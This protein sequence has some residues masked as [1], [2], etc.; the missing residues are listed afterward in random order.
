MDP[1]S[2]PVLVRAF[3]RFGQNE[4]SLFSFL[5]SYEPFGLRAYCERDSDAVQPFRLHNL[6]D[7]VRANFGHRLAVVSYRSHWSTIEAAIE[8]FA[9]DDPTEIQVLKTV[10]LL[11][12]IN[13]DDL[14]AT[15]GAVAWAV[16]GADAAG[17]ERVAGILKRLK[18]RN[19]LFIR[20][21][22][23]G[24]PLWS[25]SSVD[26]EARIE[27]A[28]RRVPIIAQASAV[29]RELLDTRPLV[30]RRHYI[31]TGNL[32]YFAV[33][34]CTTGELKELAAK[35]GM[36]AD[37][38]ILVP[39]CETEAE[40]E[41]ALV[42]AG[43]LRNRPDGRI[44][45]VAV[46]HA[47]ERLKG[48]LL[49]RQRWEWIS[50]NTPELNSDAMARGEVSRYLQDADQRLQDRVQDFIGLN[51]L[52]GRTAL[53][54][55]LRGRRLR[56]RTGREVMALLSQLCEEC[57]EKAPRISNELVNR[58]T[59]SNSAMAARMRLIDLMLTRHREA[60]L[61][62]PEDRRPPEISMY[63]SVLQAAGLHIKQKDGWKFVT[64]PSS[65]VA[66]VRPT[67]EFFEE[68]VIKRPDERVSVGKLF[69]TLRRPPY[70]LRDGLLPILFAVVMIVH[71][72]ELAVYENG[73]FVRELD[74]DVFLRLIKA[75]ERFDVQHCRIEGVRSEL[76]QRL[77]DLLE[78]SPKGA[79]R[80]EL[81]KLV[82]DLCLFVANLPEYSRNTK[83]LSKVALAVRETI[84]QAR[85]PIRLIF[86]ELPGA[87]GLTSF[88]PTKKSKQSDAIVFAK[89][90][91]DSLSEL[92]MAHA[93]LELRF[94]QQV[95]AAFHL[96][97]MPA[98][99]MRTQLA[100]RA[101]KLM[102]TI[103]ETRLRAFCVRLLDGGG[104]ESDW[105]E[106]VG[107]FLAARPPSKWQ[108]DDEDTCEREMTMLGG[109][110][111]RAETLSLTAPGAGQGLRLLLTQADGEER[112]SVVFVT[113]ADAA[114]I[115][116]VEA[117]VRAAIADDERVGLLATSRVLWEYLNVMKKKS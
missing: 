114:A 49:E 63:L 51:R 70:G 37:G 1:F 65:D 77:S 62:V 24:Y 55:F 9:S 99:Q 45:L 40:R 6:F 20:G 87:C 18:S 95:A 10:G 58:Q 26:I 31:E 101:E 88:T 85:E 69:E 112:E 78:L 82:K 75:P 100:A 80:A 21:S 33:R 39:L 91:K 56:V 90:L 30:A 2:I 50:G 14:L 73:T 104:T 66:G 35:D 17:R 48:L 13:A 107:S 117:K 16:A 57:Y 7:F 109:R 42:Q 89:A 94:E 64:K 105:I 83:R 72:Q 41:D 22:A 3:Q 68:E 32:R 52:V 29:V 12:L 61:G 34:Y 60:N 67:L 15:E 115:S 54:W 25:H 116:A 108:D 81:L 110:F 76:F 28:K 98:R 111:M 102:A 96:G 36:T 47:L 113:P 38:E 84:L 4:R 44:L 103:K 23:R 106:S 92:R 27:E 59:L 53:V 97:K 19:T 86:Y 79:N 5:F 71:E 8:S 43:G 46:P 93:G 74:K 11:N